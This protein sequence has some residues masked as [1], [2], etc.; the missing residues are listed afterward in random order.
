MGSPFCFLPRAHPTEA[1][2]RPERAPVP[3]RHRLRLGYPRLSRISSFSV[4]L[5][6][7]FRFTKRLPRTV[8][9]ECS[10]LF[11]TI[12]FFVLISFP[13]TSSL[14]RET[15]AS[16]FVRREGQKVMRS[17][18]RQARLCGRSALARTRDA[19]GDDSSALG[20][21]SSSG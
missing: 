17:A 3:S 1:R 20:A 18:I 7:S 2:C 8:A 14:L 12:P 19:F 4:H 5:Y 10:S 16:L 6:S 9:R 21:L 13:T 11:F 15:S